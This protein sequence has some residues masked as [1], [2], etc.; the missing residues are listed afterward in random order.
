MPLL[1]PSPAS[2]SVWRPSGFFY[3]PLTAASVG[4]A[5]GYMGHDL[6]IGLA[7]NREGDPI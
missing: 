1:L 3:D 7:A 2:E 4:V 5:S 6:Q